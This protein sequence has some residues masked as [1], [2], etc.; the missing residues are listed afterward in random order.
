MSRSSRYRSC[1]DRVGESGGECGNGNVASGGGSNWILYV[2]SG[3]Q[4]RLGRLLGRRGGGGRVRVRI[5]A[6]AGVSPGKWSVSM[7]CLC[8]RFI[9]LRVVCERFALRSLIKRDALGSGRADCVNPIARVETAGDVRCLF[10][11]TCPPVSSVGARGVEAGCVCC[12]SSGV[13]GGSTL[14]VAGGVPLTC[15]RGAILAIGEGARAVAPL[16]RLIAAAMLL[17][18][19]GPKCVP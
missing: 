2:G 18:S 15:G 7:D 8:I 17:R 3:R 14:P 9:R 13:G 6:E 10:A 5:G 16:G 19:C 1:W 11:V 12:L 4:P